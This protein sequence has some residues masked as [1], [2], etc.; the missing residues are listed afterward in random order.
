M[1]K[2]RVSTAGRSAAIILPEEVLS[3]LKV[4]VGDFLY[5]TEFP[6]GY[7]YLTSHDPGAVQDES[8]AK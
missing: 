1:F 2:V 7:F 5:L 8:L 3:R 6:D 4:G